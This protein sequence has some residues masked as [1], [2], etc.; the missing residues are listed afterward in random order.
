MTQEQITK[1][2]KALTD[3]GLYDQGV[4][5]EPTGIP[6]HIKEPV[7]YYKWSPGGY[8]GGSCW[9]S[10]NCQPYTTSVSD[11]EKNEVL[12]MVIKELNPN[13]SY[14]KYREIESK[15]HHNDWSDSEYY[16]N[17]T[18]WEIEYILVSD[19][20]AILEVECPDY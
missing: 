20:E 9:E 4:F 8:S 10:S 13:I 19:I 17:C 18:D 11:R 1:I 3:K 16:G 5:T 7:V 6:N 14:M 2:N 12:N 15:I